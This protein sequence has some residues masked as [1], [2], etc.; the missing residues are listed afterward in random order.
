MLGFGLLGL[1]SDLEIHIKV[2][3]NLLAPMW[4]STVLLEDQSLEVSHLMEHCS[5]EFILMFYVLNKRFPMIIMH[6]F[7][8]MGIFSTSDLNRVEFGMHLGMKGS[9]IHENFML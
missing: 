8:N 9:L 2:I 1:N 5:A 3:L 4:W 7:G 6:W